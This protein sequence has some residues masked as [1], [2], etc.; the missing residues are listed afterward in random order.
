MDFRYQPLSS[1]EIRLLKPLSRSSHPLSFEVIHT[2]LFSKPRYVA[3]SYTWG[4]PGNIHTI[5]LNEQRL[6]IRQNLKD[7]LHQIQSS[8]LVDR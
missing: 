1:H 5:L 2:S 3:L 8:K 4:S 7:A 6:L